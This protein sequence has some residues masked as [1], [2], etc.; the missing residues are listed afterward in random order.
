[1]TLS[2]LILRA[3]ETAASEPAVDPLYIGGGAFLFLL[4]LVAILMAFGAGREHS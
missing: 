4:A 2:S 3:S 1:M